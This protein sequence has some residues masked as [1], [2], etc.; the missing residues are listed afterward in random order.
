MLKLRSVSLSFLSSPFSLPSSSSPFFSLLPSPLQLANE[1]NSVITMSDKLQT[2]INL[3][4]KFEEEAQRHAALIE[5]KQKII[6]AVRLSVCLSVLLCFFFPF[7]FMLL[8]NLCVCGCSSC[9]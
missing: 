3:K 9:V 5:E 6:E 4:E 8:L 7:F 2:L 1:R